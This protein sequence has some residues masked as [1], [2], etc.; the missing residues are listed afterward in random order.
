M[1][2]TSTLTVAGCDCGK[3][4]LHICVL[5]AE[6][7]PKN[8]KSFARSYK[9]LV[10]K[11]NPQDVETLLALN[12]DVY[13]LEPTGSYSYI[14]LEILK[15][16]GRTVRLVSSRRVR[17]FC[18]YQGVVNKADRP[19]AAAIAVYTI[20]NISNEQAFLKTE[21][22][23][24]R[25]LYLALNS[26]TRSKNPVYNRLGQRLSHEFPE[27]IDTYENTH[28][29]WLDGD[30]PAVYR[31]LAGEECNGPY[32]K[33]RIE[34]LQNTIGSGISAHTRA[35]ARQLCE[36][37]RME[38]AI[39]T[40][41][42][43]EMSKPEFEIYNRVFDRFQIPQR[44][45][46]AI[47]SRIYPFEDFLRDGK[48]FK[49]YIRGSNSHRK[50]GMTKRD[51]SEGEFKLCL[52][53]GKVL[54][55]SGNSENWKAGGAKYARTALWLYIKS[56]VVIHRSRARKGK[57]AVDFNEV[58]SK[59]EREHR[60]DGLSPWLNENLIQAVAQATDT[61]PE[62]AALRLHFEFQID[63]KGDRRTSATAGRFCRMLYKAL[64]KEFTGRV[65]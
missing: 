59:L 64:L 12:A 6:D 36:F 15:R 16:A 40:D 14:W 7:R 43:A 34:K 53:M 47:L 29:D 4:S 8:L 58:V 35:L 57:G 45:R 65:E 9:P 49:E 26:T 52:G 41:L 50:S 27:I 56:I 30:A 1:S 42:A 20:D 33:Q 32:S 25:E 55:Q 24:I 3:D 51:R 54:Q 61:T 60:Q 22:I 11:A 44:C 37:E 5:K 19:D 39:E 28:R 31:F 21:R 17:H 46:A 23:K 2:S 48:P 62:V 63:K 10:L 18:E 13:V 38:L